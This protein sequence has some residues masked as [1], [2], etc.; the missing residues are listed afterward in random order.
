MGCSDYIPTGEE[1]ERVA[2]TAF[3]G[4]V[5]NEIFVCSRNFGS[6]VGLMVSISHSLSP[7]P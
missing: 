2:K 7:S 5:H 3:G 1:V 6:W 4:D